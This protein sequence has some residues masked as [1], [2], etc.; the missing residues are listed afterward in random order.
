MV[1]RREPHREGQV[2]SSTLTASLLE[3]RLVDEI[4]VMVNPVLP[5]G[6]KSLFSGLRDRIP[7]RLARTTVFTSG[8]VLLTFEPQAR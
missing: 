7:L 5:G 6:G 3:Q 1:A 4:R 8:N 2:W